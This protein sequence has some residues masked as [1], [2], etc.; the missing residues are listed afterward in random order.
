MGRQPLRRRRGPL[1]CTQE[2]CGAVGK[3][4]QSDGYSE[5]TPPPPASSVRRQA[6]KNVSLIDP[7]KTVWGVRLQGTHTPVRTRSRCH[8]GERPRL[9]RRQRRARQHLSA[10]TTAP[11]PRGRG[12]T[13]RSKR[14][15][16][17][18]PTQQGH[19]VCPPPGGGGQVRLMSAA[20][21]MRDGGA[22]VSTTPTPTPTRPGEGCANARS[23]E[24]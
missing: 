8:D 4:R 5:S 15:W 1:P 2:R 9:R 11:H 12:D 21:R 22:A 19:T 24:R 13:K 16:H 14:R 17:P 7:H 18:R 20:R 10:S 6:G 3:P 23:W